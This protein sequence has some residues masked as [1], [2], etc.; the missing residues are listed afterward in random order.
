MT[1]WRSR[2][3]SDDDLSTL[4]SGIPEWL[5]RPLMLW[6]NRSIELIS[7]SLG[8][9][10]SNT[11]E[12]EVIQDYETLTRS[13]ISLISA[14]SSSGIQGIHRTLDDEGF[15][16]FID[17]LVFRLSKGDWNC[18]NQIKELE[19]ILKKSGSEWELG[20]RE[21]FTSLVQRVPAGVSEAVVEI[22]GSAGNAGKL[23]QEAWH[24][25]FGRNPDPEEAYEKAIKAVE[26]AA[27]PIISPNNSM[28]TLGSMLS[29]LKSQKDWKLHLAGK[30]PDVPV[31]MIDA[32]WTGQ[33]SRHG[34]NGYRKP[35]QEEAETAVLLAVPLVQFVMSG[36]FRRVSQESE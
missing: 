16:D 29:E 1:N 14:Y 23:L 20:K 19:I 15:L 2:N 18:S 13:R 17:Y 36:L 6:S 7:D 5:F 26:E 32:L 8:K 30:N 31:A 9:P 28:A 12:I 25:A 27:A 22:I 3:I 33:E 35:S 24:F 21:G 10:W 4:Y 34:G 11:S